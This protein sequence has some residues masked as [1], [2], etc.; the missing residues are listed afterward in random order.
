MPVTRPEVGMVQ[1]EAGAMEI[2]R[3]CLAKVPPP[4]PPESPPSRPQTQG[5]GY[6]PLEVLQLQAT[7]TTTTCPSFSSFWSLE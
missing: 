5:L 2:D 4:P 1:N 6:H 7:A 3:H